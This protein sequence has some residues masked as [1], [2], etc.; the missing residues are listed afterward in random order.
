M[1]WEARWGLKQGY[2][3]VF[4]ASVHCLNGVGGP[5]EGRKYSGSRIGVVL[6]VFDEL[7]V[8]LLLPLFLAQLCQ[9]VAVPCP[10]AAPKKVP[11]ALVPVRK[12]PCSHSQAA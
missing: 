7:P 11:L 3:L 2:L 12:P 10:A 8:V 4:L 6:A 5:L 1:A 9:L